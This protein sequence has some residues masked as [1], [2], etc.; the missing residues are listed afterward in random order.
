MNELQEKSLKLIEEFFS[1]M[2]GVA[3]LQEH[4]ALENNVGPTL[5]F[6]L[7]SLKNNHY[8]SFI[9]MKSE[10]LPMPKHF[11]IEK[12]SYSSFDGKRNGCYAANDEIYPI[13]LAA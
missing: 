2:D 10:S 6:F 11:E 8:S 1:N 4:E 5:E 7:D 13:R 3:F 12:R 9:K